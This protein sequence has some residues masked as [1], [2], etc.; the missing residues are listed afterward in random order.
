MTAPKRS[1]SNEGTKQPHITDQ[2]ITF[3]NWHKHIAWVNMLFVAVIPLFGIIMTYSTPLLWKTAI[4]ALI[5]YFLTGLGITAGKLPLC[6]VIE[7][8]EN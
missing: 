7:F 4:W 1:G 8:Y 3:S 6:L 5:Y 2:P